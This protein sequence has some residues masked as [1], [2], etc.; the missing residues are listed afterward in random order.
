MQPAMPID[1]IMELA[2][3]LSPLDKLKLI[4]GLAPDLE[5]ALRAD[6]TAQG[7]LS[8]QD[9]QYQQ[10]YERIPEDIADVEAM[11]PHLPIPPERWE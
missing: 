9:N 5:A 2:R 11:L 4:Q 6:S 10:G 1:R 7:E 3:R 8:A